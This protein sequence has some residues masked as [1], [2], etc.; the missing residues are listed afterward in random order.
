MW[1]KHRAVKRRLSSS[2]LTT[3]G[4]RGGSNAMMREDDFLPVAEDFSRLNALL[5][6]AMDRILI[7]AY[8]FANS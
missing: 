2:K 5:C 7:P 3:D 4:E 6:T 8:C 1:M